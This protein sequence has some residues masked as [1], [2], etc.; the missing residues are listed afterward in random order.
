MSNVVYGNS[1]YG[2]VGS[3]TRGGTLGPTNG[4]G[5]DSPNIERGEKSGKGEERD[6]EITRKP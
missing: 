1:V 5:Q 3:G 6:P 2:V 4:L